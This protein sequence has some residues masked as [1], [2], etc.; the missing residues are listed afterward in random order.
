MENF[1]DLLKLKREGTVKVNQHHD[2]LFK[3]I[4]KYQYLFVSSI[5]MKKHFLK[6]YIKY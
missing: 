3:N 4:F 1:N 2:K 6:T 5:Y